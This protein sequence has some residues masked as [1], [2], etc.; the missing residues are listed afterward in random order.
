ME[1]ASCDSKVEDIRARVAG[2][3][4]DERT[5]LTTDYFNHFNEVI[6][7]FSML[8]DMPEML[9][10][11]DQWAYKSY[12][13]HFQESG[14]GIAPLA[15]EAYENAPPEVR[16][17]FDTIIDGLKNLIIESRAKLRHTLEEGQTEK[18]SEM[19]RMLTLEL[20]ALVDDGGAV[21]HG[22]GGAADQSKIDE[23]F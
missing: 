15:I 7:L 16:Q 1:A 8:P 4:I 14:L 10:D 2:T 17:R 22:Y 6:M 12:N 18:F 3:N 9:D 21:V 13:E 11:V 19:C 23:M 5:F 20:Q